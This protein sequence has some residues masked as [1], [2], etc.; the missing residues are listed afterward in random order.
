M[1]AVRLR[2]WSPGDAAAIAPVLDDPQVLR[3]S[4]IAELGADRWIAEQRQGRR[5]PSMVV[6][7]ADDD[8]VLGKVALRLP[9]KAS[10]ATNCDA[11]W[12]DD[13][14]VGELSYWVLPQARGR[15]IAT[16]AVFAMLNVARQIEGIRSVVLDIETDNMPSIRVAERVGATR[17]QPTRVQRDRHGVPRTLAVFII[18]L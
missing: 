7:E 13:H 16:S 15:G 9:G 14:P 6:C 18:T 1:T 11:I 4:H 5:G 2:A 10:P 17:R 8:R 3:W 12:A